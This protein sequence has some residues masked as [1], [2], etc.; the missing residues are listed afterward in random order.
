MCHATLVQRPSESFGSQ[1]VRENVGDTFTFPPEMPVTS[2]SCE[3]HKAALGT[4]NSVLS[5][6]PKPGVDAEGTVNVPENCI[7]GV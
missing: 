2:G 6:A 3:C 1:E 7:A 5:L 4:S